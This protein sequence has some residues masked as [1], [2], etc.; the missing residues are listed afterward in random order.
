MKFLT[1]LAQGKLQVRLRVTVNS[2]LTAALFLKK[3]NKHLQSCVVST[4]IA[5]Q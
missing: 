4:K 5:G 1:K 2:F 3:H